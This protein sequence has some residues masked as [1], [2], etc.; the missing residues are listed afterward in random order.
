VR[1]VGREIN[2]RFN[3]PSQSQSAHAWCLLMGIECIENGALCCKMPVASL[4][5]RRANNNNNNNRL[6]TVSRLIEHNPLL[7]SAQPGKIITTDAPNLIGLAK[8]LIL[9][10]MKVRPQ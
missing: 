6:K 1:K 7:K 5:L 8:K 3:E 10:L 4:P 9:R 2:L